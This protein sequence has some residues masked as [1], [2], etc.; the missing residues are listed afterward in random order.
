MNLRESLLQRIT[1]ESQKPPLE[2]KSLLE[3]FEIAKQNGIKGI[4][5]VQTLGREIP[6]GSEIP[7][8]E[9]ETNYTLFTKKGRCVIFD[10]A[11]G[12]FPRSETDELKDLVTAVSRANILSSRRILAEVADGWFGE[13]N[14][15]GKH[16]KMDIRYEIHMLDHAEA[17]GIKAFPHPLLETN[18]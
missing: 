8:V 11:H 10:E 4:A 3:L 18:Q 5:V 7:D 14:E 2:V 9:H 15:P 13:R 16:S 17:Q 1:P 6:S 12:T